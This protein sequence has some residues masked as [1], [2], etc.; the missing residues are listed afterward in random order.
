[1]EE[2]LEGLGIGMFNYTFGKLKIYF[3][4]EII[5]SKK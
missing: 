2:K 3:I 4:L 5:Q 1:M